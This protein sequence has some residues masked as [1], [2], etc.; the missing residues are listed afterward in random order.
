MR[1]SGQYN[2]ITYS[3]QFISYLSRCQSAVWNLL[4][5][6]FTTTREDEHIWHYSRLCV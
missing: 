1:T 6:H 5:T 4:Q 3:K 2:C